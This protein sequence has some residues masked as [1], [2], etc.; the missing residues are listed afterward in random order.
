MI[1]VP[2]GALA[3]LREPRVAWFF[4]GVFCT[5]LAHTA[6]YAFFSLYLVSLGYTKTAVGVIWAVGVLAEV[7]VGVRGYEY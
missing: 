5:V 1:E 3:I 7:K 4:A 2:R 6:L